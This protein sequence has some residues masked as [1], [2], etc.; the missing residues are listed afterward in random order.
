M[1]KKKTI[2]VTVFAIAFLALTAALLFYLH[3]PAVHGIGA[4]QSRNDDSTDVGVRRD[5]LVYA[6][7]K[8]IAQPSP[9]GAL[10]SENA[11][12][13]DTFRQLVRLSDAGRADASLRLFRDLRTCDLRRGAQ[14]ALDGVYYHHPGQDA[15][16]YAG[17][18]KQAIEKEPAL[19]EALDQL[20]RSDAL[21]AGMSAQQIGA[22]G[23]YLRRAALQNDPGTMV[24]Y[25]GSHELGPGY[26]SDA[27]FDY[28]SR[29]QLEAPSMAQRALD[30]GEPGILALLIDAY[31]PDDPD[32]RRMYALSEVFA[33]DP[34][35]AYALSLVYARLAQGSELEQA[36]GV[37]AR[38]SAVMQPGQIAN[39]RAQA[40]A[41][42]PQFEQHSGSV[43]TLDPCHA[44]LS[45]PGDT[46]GVM[47]GAP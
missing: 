15:A 11:P 9:P 22:R 42:W 41:L 27:W 10:P 8:P 12:L 43:R 47:E 46:I 19:K 24:C 26:L 38:L 36:Q 6:D 37:L 17:Q 31:L 28:A 44:F 13:E 21:C 18:I 34:Q 5:S 30:A 35:L 4:T 1:V 39:A 29:W 14:R 7:G 23:E 25:L 40:D 45:L 2:R 32:A 20:D 33:P 3:A 16:A